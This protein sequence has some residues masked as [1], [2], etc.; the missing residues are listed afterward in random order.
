MIGVGAGQDGEVGIAVQ[1]F[2]DFRIKAAHGVGQ[3]P[4]AAVA[5]MVVHEDPNLIGGG[6]NEQLLL[7]LF[8]HFVHVHELFT[9]GGGG[10][11][12]A[13]PLSDVF[14]V[15]DGLSLCEHFGHKAFQLAVGLLYVH[16]RKSLR[17]LHRH[18]PGLD[19]EKGS[20]HHNGDDDQGKV[21]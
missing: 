2:E 9:D 8:F 14:P 11:I 21:G 13:D 12:L 16:F 20:Q 4:P 1:A 15:G 10:G 17:L 19:V 5:E 7:H 3:V 6:L 18:L